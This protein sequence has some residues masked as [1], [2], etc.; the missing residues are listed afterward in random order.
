MAASAQKSLAI[1]LG[2][3]V[4]CAVKEP[5]QTLNCT[6]IADVCECTC[7][8]IMY[9]EKKAINKLKAQGLDINDYI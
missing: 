3:S 9:I 7:Q 4:L 6:E 1:D 2:L 5:G 8:N